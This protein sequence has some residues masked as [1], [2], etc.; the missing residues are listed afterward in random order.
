MLKKLDLSVI[1]E[2]RRLER[3]MKDKPL[4]TSYSKKDSSGNYI[5]PD[6]VISADFKSIMDLAVKQDIRNVLGNF[7]DDKKFRSFMSN[8][9]FV[10][11][12]PRKLNVAM[13][14]Y[15]IINREQWSFIKSEIPVYEAELELVA[16]TA[17]KKIIDPYL[18]AG[19]TV[20]QGEMA[21]NVG[22]TLKTMKLTLTKDAYYRMR[23]KYLKSVKA[24][25]PTTGLYENEATIMKLIVSKNKDISQGNLIKELMRQPQW[26]FGHNKT[27]TFIEQ[28]VKENQ[29]IKTRDKVTRKWA[30]S[31]WDGKL[32]L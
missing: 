28:A 26:M 2:A 21:K 18:K 1:D 29:L 15:G 22:N 13:Y 23:V 31:V 20:A 7:R 10:V 32:L 14:D 24:H 3:N 11:D 9:I 12:N 27:Y 6:Y 4:D 30:Y 8:I 25:N 17:E 16:E 5:I 19:L